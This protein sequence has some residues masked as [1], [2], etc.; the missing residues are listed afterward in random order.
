MS[1]KSDLWL[2]LPLSPHTFIPFSTAICFCSQSSLRSP[3]LPEITSSWH[4][5]YCL[6]VIP[7]SLHL[8]LLTGPSL[9]YKTLLSWFTEGVIIFIALNF[10][11]LLCPLFSFSSP[12]HLGGRVT[13]SW[14]LSFFEHTLPHHTHS[15][16]YPHLSK[17]PRHTYPCIWCIHALPGDSMLTQ[18]PLTGPHISILKMWHISGSVL[19]AGCSAANTWER[20]LSS[21]SFHSR[22]VFLVFV[23]NFAY[24][25][26][27]EENPVLS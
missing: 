23:F 9:I 3:Q 17:R 14:S 20:F 8:P 18:N 15:S 10:S 1:G 6:V 12:L 22:E 7:L 5:C 13:A 24:T 25:I 19:G 11:S 21:W 26:L 27:M 16:Q 2:L 4:W